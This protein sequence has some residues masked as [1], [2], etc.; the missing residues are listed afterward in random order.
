VKAHLNEIVFALSLF[1]MRI[2]GGEKM[3]A[4]VATN[5]WWDTDPVGDTLKSI[6]T[7]LEDI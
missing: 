3:I 2:A 1:V 6:E 7:F 4:L 5:S